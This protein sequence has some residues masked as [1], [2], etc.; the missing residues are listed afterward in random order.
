VKRDVCIAGEGCGQPPTE[1]PPQE[2]LA[3]WNEV[4]RCY[5]IEETAAAAQR[6]LAAHAC[7]FCEVCQLLCPDQ[8]ITRDPESGAIQIDLNYCKG[9]GLCA[10]LCPKGAI[11]ME[12]E[13]TEGG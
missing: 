2:R 4:V 9:C 12:P 10:Y 3:D 5:G 6:C 13:Q 1:R 7:T 8:C 11:H